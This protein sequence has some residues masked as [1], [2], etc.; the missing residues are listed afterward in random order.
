[1]HLVEQ[2]K[3]LAACQAID[4]QVKPNQVIGI[5]SGSTIVYAVQ[6]LAELHKNGLAVKACI[7]SSFQAQNL[8]L[9]I[10]V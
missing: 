2:A 4:E 3:K 1:M 8:I 7:P 5:G 9:G 6:R 10:L